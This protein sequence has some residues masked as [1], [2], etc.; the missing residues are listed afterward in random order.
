[1]HQYFLFLAFQISVKD[2]TL[3]LPVFL[4]MPEEGI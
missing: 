2:V 3:T 1:M 4:A